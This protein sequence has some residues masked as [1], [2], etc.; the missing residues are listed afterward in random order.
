MRPLTQRRLEGQIYSNLECSF[1]E[2]FEVV[3]TPN[4]WGIEDYTT[5]DE[6]EDQQ[7]YLHTDHLGSSSFITDQSGEAVQHLQYMAFG[8][9]FVNQTSTSWETRFTFSGKEKDAET[10]YSYFG[11]RYYDSDLSVW[12]SVDPLADKYPSMSSFM[13]AAGNPVMLVDPDGREIEQDQPGF[14]GRIARVWPGFWGPHKGYGRWNK[15]LNCHDFFRNA[16][17]RKNKGPKRSLS[18]RINIPRMEVTKYKV[19]KESQD[20]DNIP[21]TWNSP[22]NR[23]YNIDSHFS[24]TINYDFQNVP[25]RMIVTYTNSDGE[26]IIFN[27]GFTS[28]TGTIVIPEGSRN[29]NVTVL[30]N[31]RDSRSTVYEY[32]IVKNP[33]TV[34]KKTRTWW[35]G[36]IPSR[37]KKEKLPISKVDNTDT[38]RKWK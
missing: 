2:L 25:D 19:K 22:S 11:A 38:K 24:Y 13:Y 10:G 32:S 8:E 26:L 23:N 28:G 4:L 34:V 14:W 21:Q 27:T 35:L 5:I 15:W 7:Y 33:K 17:R 29:L 30:P 31:S 18:I 16:G 36:I 1:G 20:F 6:P 9:S 3:M 12:L 37:K